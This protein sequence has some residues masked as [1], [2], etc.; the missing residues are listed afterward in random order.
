MH[1]FNFTDFISY[2]KPVTLKKGCSQAHWSAHGM[3]PLDIDGYNFIFIIKI[4]IKI[5][6]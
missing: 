1:I 6:V 3:L 5:R 2:L 4:I